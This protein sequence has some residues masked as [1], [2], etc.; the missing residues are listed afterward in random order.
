[1]AS[2]DESASKEPLLQPRVVRLLKER[3]RLVDFGLR[4]EMLEELDNIA[5]E[6]RKPVNV[7]QRATDNALNRARDAAK[8]PMQRRVEKRVDEINESIL[9]GL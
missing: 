8:R 2:P 4:K 5:T 9:E 6:R 7:A 1:M 3:P